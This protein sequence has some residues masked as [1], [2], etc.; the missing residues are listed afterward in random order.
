VNP[1][2]EAVD[3]TR[4]FGDFVAVDHVTFSIAPGTIWGFLG[5]NGAG[6]ST[7]I[8]MLCGVLAPTSGRATVLGYDV[9][10]DPERIKSS[11]GYMSQK[12]GVWPDLTVR[13]H[14]E[15]FGGIYGLSTRET[16]E[17][18]E[19][20]MERLGLVDSADELAARLPGGF[21]Q[22]LAFVCAALPDPAILFLDEP[23]AGVDPISR[24]EFWD[25]I[26]S[27]AETGTTIVVTTHYLD[28]AEHCNSLAFIH[29]GRI[30]ASG[31]PEALKHNE[32]FGVAIE[33]R[34]E[35]AGSRALTIVEGL[36]SVRA[37]S[38]FGEALHVMVANEADGR[39]VYEAVA[40]AGLQPTLPVRIEPT[41]E[42]VFAAVL[43]SQ[44]GVR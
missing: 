26:G 11:I 38:L 33:M 41:L 5:P 17:R 22:R 14:I 37:A 21:R 7:T 19:T 43:S 39:L 9:A 32:S 8:R 34:A 36:P 23:T 15:L 29:D 30:V 27:L 42:D 25:V 28:E 20:W 40:N 35:H 2:I 12:S 6:K 1:A 24:R 31:T 16:H 44:A 10:T 3:L 4:R 13:E 18:M